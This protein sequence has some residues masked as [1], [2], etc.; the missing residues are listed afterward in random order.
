M[1]SEM[2]T[3]T[4]TVEEIENIAREKYGGKA[5]FFIRDLPLKEQIDKWY[6]MKAKKLKKDCEQD[7]FDFIE[8]HCLC[9][10]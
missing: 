4:N 1:E 7:Y 5:Y 9:E 10:F 3:Q 2:N 6:R 8:R